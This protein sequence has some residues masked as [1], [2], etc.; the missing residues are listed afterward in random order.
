M[1][2]EHEQDK[3][4]TRR[5]AGTA[6]RAIENQAQRNRDNKN[7]EKV[8][9]EQQF[10]RLL[11]RLADKILAGITEHVEKNDH[12]YY[13]TELPNFRAQCDEIFGNKF[14]DFPSELVNSWLYS[15]DLKHILHC[16]GNTLVW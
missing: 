4:F 11:D 10:F 7:S 8:A 12:V 1:R 5:I 13:L 2:M 14:G 6:I 9:Q 3:D 15:R 16:D